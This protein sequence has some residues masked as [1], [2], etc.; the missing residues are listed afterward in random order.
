MLFASPIAKLGSCNCDVDAPG[1]AR[2]DPETSFFFKRGRRE[3]GSEALAEE[4]KRIS[5]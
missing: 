2:S 5:G 1:K 3:G 4:T